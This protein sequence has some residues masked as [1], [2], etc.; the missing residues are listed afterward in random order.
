MGGVG[1]VGVVVETPVFGD[2][3]GPDEAG[4]ERRRVASA[5]RTGQRRRSSIPLDGH[6]FAVE[7]I[8]HVQ[9][10]QGAAVG[11]VPD[12]V[13][14]LQSP[15]FWGQ[16]HTVVRHPAIVHMLGARRRREPFILAL[17]ESAWANQVEDRVA[18]GSQC[19]LSSPDGWETREEGRN[20]TSG[21][22]RRLPRC[23]H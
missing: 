15:A 8:E 5:S 20:A 11:G 14:C 9:H 2:H 23:F 12:L 10:L 22:L 13:Q 1:S 18:T 16:A 6:C 7:L 17:P 19:S 4:A 21:R 3:A